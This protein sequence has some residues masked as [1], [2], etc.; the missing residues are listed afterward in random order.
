[1]CT[2][3]CPTVAPSATAPWCSTRPRR[4][5]IWTPWPARCTATGW[6]STPAKSLTTN[7][8]SCGGAARGIAT[9]SPTR[10]GCW[11]QS[12]TPTRPPT[13]SSTPP[14]WPPAITRYRC[15]N[16][17][18]ITSAFGLAQPKRGCRPA[19]GTPAAAP[20][21]VIGDGADV[22]LGFDGS[23]S[24]DSTA[25]VAATC[26]EHPHILVVGCWEKPARAADDWTVPIADVE[27]TI[28]QACRRYSVREICCDPYGYRRSM[29]ILE[30]EG[31][32]IVDYPQSS[33]RMTPA[34]Q[35][36]YEL[37]ANR[38]L[39]HDGDRRLARHIGNAVLKVDSRGQRLAKEHKSSTRKID[40]AIAAVMA[41]DRA[42][43]A[44]PYDLLASFI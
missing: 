40:L 4:A 30:E 41:V 21:V 16:S 1:M 6:R 12:V 31:L 9:T 7:S 17:C 19:C 5:G 22:V 10:R 18:A 32:P 24:E 26:D 37:V 34:T 23:F 14:T 27:E 35:R 42:T 39:S 36:F 13:S 2:W 15:T 43:V 29:Q 33:Q 3:C 38:G 11:R 28:R 44:A 25:L 8:C 20:N